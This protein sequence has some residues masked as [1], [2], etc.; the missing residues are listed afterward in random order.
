MSHIHPRVPA[1]PVT[2]QPL[3]MLQPRGSQEQVGE[4]PAPFWSPW[5]GRDR[6]CLRGSGLLVARVRV[7]WGDVLCR[8]GHFVHRVTFCAEGNE[9]GS[10]SA[11]SVTLCTKCSPRRPAGPPCREGRLRPGLTRWP[12]V[13]WSG[14]GVWLWGVE[15]GRRG[16]S[17]RGACWSCRP[18]GGGA[19]GVC[20][21]VELACRSCGGRGLVATG[22]GVV[23]SAGGVG[24]CCTFILRSWSGWW[25]GSNGFPAREVS[26]DGMNVQRG[27]RCTFIM[28]HGPGSSGGSA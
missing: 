20:F 28:V 13:A 12:P 23:V 22:R 15:V 16:R 7:A 6:A 11:Q 21:R 8:A 18:V 4:R 1:G 24:P 26:G 3:E 2:I 5:R 9:S 17:H 10:F 25:R 14:Q 27:S 19:Q